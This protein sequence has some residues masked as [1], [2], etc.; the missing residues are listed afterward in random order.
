MGSVQFNCTLFSSHRFENDFL[1]IFNMKYF[2]L[3]LVVGFAA[4]SGLSDSG[5]KFE[6]GKV[7]EFEY[8][9]RLMTGIPALANQYSGLGI[10]ATVSLV[11]KT[12]TTFGIV[13]SS[14]KFVKIN[15]VLTP[16]QDNIPSTYEGTNWRRLQLPE[17]V[18]VPAEFKKILAEPVVVE[19][20]GETGEVIKMVISKNE[21][22]WSANFK[23]GIVSLFQVKME[24]GVSTNMIEK[25]TIESLPYWKVM[26]ETVAGKC[27]ATYQVNQLPEYIVKE[28]PTL[29]PFPESC[30]EKKY[31][32]IVRT[33]DFDNCEKQSSFSF[34]RPGHFMQKG[35]SDSVNNV[36]SM[37]S[38]SSTTRRIAC[39]SPAAGLTIQTIVNDGEFDFQLIGTKTERVVSGSLQVLRLK[40]VKPYSGFPQP[41]VPVTLKSMLFEYTQKAYGVTGKGVTTN[42]VTEQLSSEPL[43]EGRIP[44]SELENG[45]VLA[46]SIPRTFFQGINSETTPSKGEFVTEIT[47]LFKEVMAVI[48]AESSSLPLTESE[49][50]MRILTA[51]RGMTTLETVEEI[52]GLYTTLV[53]GLNPEQIETMKQLFIDTI[54]M[55]GTPQSI[56]FFAKMV[57]EGKV[58]QTE[59]SSFF[60]FLPRYIMTPTQKVLKG[61]FKLVTEVETITKVPTTYSLAITSLS[62]LV[63]SACI[64]ESRI[65][66]FPVHVFGEFCTPESEIVQEVL[67]PYLARTLHKTPQTKMEEEVRNIHL[68]ALGLI[69]HK[70]VIPELTPVID[71]RLSVSTSTVEGS[72]NSAARVL[73]VWSLM[74]V[75]YQNPHLVIPVLTNVFT[76]PAE[77]TEM[78]IAAFNSLLKL[79]PPKAV[80]DTIAAQTR[81]EPQ[82]DLELLKIINIGLYTLGNQIPAE[83]VPTLP[84]GMIELIEK[85]KLA[86]HMV[87]KTYGI[88]PTTASFYK[89]EFLKDLG[90]GY[91]AQLTWIS[92]HEQIMPRAG[93]FGLGLFLQKYYIN[94]FQ[95]GFMLYGTDSVLDNLSTIVSKVTGHKSEQEIKSEIKRSLHTEFSKIM[96]KLNI[97]S[98]KSET[99]HANA[100]FQ[101]A[102]SGVIVRS[103][104]QKTS[105]LINEKIIEFIE[106]PSSILTGST[107]LKVNF[108]KTIDLS[109]IQVMFPSDM[110]FPVHVEVNAPVTVSVM[111]KA[112]IKPL[113]LLPSITVT[114]KTLLATQYSGVVSTVCPYT[115][116]YLVT[117]ISQPTVINIP[118]AMEVKLDIPSQK[119][120]V[121]VK[122][123]EQT[124]TVLAHYHIMPYTT[125][126]N[127]NK[128]ELLTK[129]PAIRPIKS[130]SPR[131]H[132]SATVGEMLGLGIKT[133]VVTES[134]FVDLRSVAEYMAIYKNPLNL[135]VFGWTSPAL[136]ENLVPS[137]RFHKMTAMFDPS[138]S[139]TKELGV[140]FKVGVAT[141]IMGET[142]VN[143]HTLILKSIASLSKSEI[144]EIMT[145]PS[146]AKLVSVLSP[147]KIVSQSIESQ[148]HMRRQQI[149]KKVISQLETSALESSV[150]TGLTLTTNV[151]IKSTRPRTFTYVLTAAA[152][153]KVVPESKKIHQEW[154]LLLESQVPQTPVK[155]ISVSGEITVPI[156][157]LWNIE[158]LRQSLVN[159][160]FHNKIVFTMANGQKSQIITTGTAKTTQAQKTFSLE[161]PEALKLKEIISPIS[162][163]SPKTVVELEEIVRLQATAL[164]KIVIESKYVNV[165]KVFEQVQMKVIEILKV[166]LWPYYTPSYSTVE[167]TKFEPGS[168]EATTEVIFKQG[169]PSFDLKIVLP[170]EKVFFSNVRIAYPFNLFFPISA[171]RIP[172]SRVVSGSVLSAKSCMIHGKHLIKFNGNT[173]DIPATVVAPV[174]VAADCSTF[175]RFA[176]KAQHIKQGT[177]NTEIILKK[178]LIKVVPTATLPTDLVNGTPIQIP[179]GKVVIV[180]DIADHT[181]IAEVLMTPDHVVVV[182]APRFLLEEVKTNGQII[183]VVPSVQLKNK[184][185]GVCGNFQK[186]IMTVTG[187]CV[188][189]KPEL[190]IASWMIP[191]GSS[192]MMSPSI[193]SELKKETEMCPKMTVL[194]T[195][196]A[197]A[198][199]VATGKCTIL[200]HLIQKGPGQVC[201]SKI[202]V[203]Q[204]GPSC[205]PQKSQLTVKAVPF[206]CLPE[207]PVV[208]KLV[209]KVIIGQE[210]PELATKVTSFATQVR[211]PSTCVHALVTKG[212]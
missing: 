148:V 67:I 52:Q 143:Y 161:S 176:I 48:R 79:N 178:N 194:P 62:Q 118:G 197:K 184:L 85:A 91:N 114:G 34:Y 202:P 168:Y 71:S 165:P 110:G 81:M 84:A 120:S 203:T 204:C 29:I 59:I 163:V 65:T 99:F 95:G 11:S 174:V 166:Y 151:I 154:H 171:A 211:M 164:D 159:F 47:K 32:E 56:E 130:T 201:L 210:L 207:G 89:T 63:Q 72:R 152:G 196:V 150:V 123:T 136:S 41:S 2:A 155:S 160:S 175:H 3:L 100:F 80:F 200:R 13:V 8:S 104:T 60:M 17:M 70:N 64:A 180:K 199:K 15:D 173:M 30:P 58:S 69:R 46:K 129:T 117:G 75:G 88:V 162:S 93:Y 191:T 137:V 68:V 119:L 177:W 50:N 101:M 179:V 78:R 1:G 193:L 94:V 12:P 45:Q 103:L 24:S 157:P 135:M 139:S 144:T 54:V 51:V 169:V 134:R 39:G 126:G 105:E 208:E 112:S 195:E 158:Q 172:I 102:E 55:T 182:K 106:N 5:L 76:N 192:S 37:V 125:V 115:S 28:D 122:P 109:P 86:Y 98:I 82:M 170:T 187:H 128:L 14:P 124:P 140:D 57:R 133:E 188:Y 9:G 83:V 77:A 20:S 22:E 167:N 183:E 49:V 113:S 16:V 31:F 33:L 42:S 26:E 27:L 6:A 73:A 87:K 18:E 53:S 145:N 127:I 205:K 108:Q 61:L 138:L 10:N 4:A 186:P 189:S 131:K 96:E 66:S 19:L 38:R 21:P 142:M 92:A 74:S 97:E 146:L 40:A 23:K 7:Y 36:G 156:L 90:A 44:R 43:A 149:L 181:V 35:S 209:A 185:C 25:P 107:E 116:E 141:K 111:G 190:E 147:L 212:I 206:T 132:M 198:Y 121:Y 153:S